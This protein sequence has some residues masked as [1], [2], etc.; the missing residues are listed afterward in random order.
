LMISLQWLIVFDT[1]HILSGDFC[2]REL[3]NHP[4]FIYD[5]QNF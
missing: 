3:N 1:S 4:G 5:P 2:C